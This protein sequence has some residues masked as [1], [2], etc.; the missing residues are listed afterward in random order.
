MVAIKAHQANA[1]LKSPSA[2]C[3][4]VLLY[5][6]DS[7]QVSERAREL[8]ARWATYGELADLI[9]ARF[10][11]P[12]ATLRELFGRIVFNVCIS[13][14][15]DHARNHAAFFDPRPGGH[16]RGAGRGRLAGGRVP[17]QPLLL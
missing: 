11:A 3:R 15:D 1:F 12:D 2:T 16:R 14:T 5:G 17:V 4:A 8:A 13:N 7:G 9:R 10:T 6:T